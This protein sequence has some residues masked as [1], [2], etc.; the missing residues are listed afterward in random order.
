MEDSPD[1]Q[2]EQNL[3]NSLPLS[4]S[5]R[6]LFDYILRVNPQLKEKYFS[7]PR[8]GTEGFGDVGESLVKSLGDFDSD[9]AFSGVSSLIKDVFAHADK[10]RVQH[11]MMLIMFGKKDDIAP[12]KEYAQ[13]TGDDTLF[14]DSTIAEF[15]VPILQWVGNTKTYP[16]TSEQEQKLRSIYDGLQLPE[17]EIYSF[18]EACM[19][20]IEGLNANISKARSM[21]FGRDGAGDFWNQPE[22]KRSYFRTRLSYA[23]DKI[24]H[25]FPPAITN[26][27]LRASIDQH[28]DVPE[29]LMENVERSFLKSFSETSGFKTVD[30][31]RHALK[32]APYALR[33]IAERLRTGNFFIVV[34]FPAHAYEEV[35]ANGVRNLSEV[36]VST[37]SSAGSIRQYDVT[38]V[39]HEAAMLGLSPREYASITPEQRPKYFLISATVPT[40][41]LATVNTRDYGKSFAAVSAKTVSGRLTLSLG[42]SLNQSNPEGMW[43]ERL[44]P[45]K[46]ADVLAPFIY[47][48]LVEQYKLPLLHTRKIQYALIFHQDGNVNRRARFPRMPEALRKL[49]Y[50]ERPYEPGFFDGVSEGFGYDYVEAQVLGP[51]ASDTFVF[52]KKD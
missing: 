15:C 19:P 42:D 6:E 17:G 11:L 5:P 20:F 16:L 25:V 3:R 21:Y 32:R 40:R 33:V 4:S 37:F 35:L 23:L 48:A 39:E 36:G 30:E 29:A 38:R 46:Y 8:W 45:G 51:V 14:L 12:I 9:V 34:N 24:A 10:S 2:E 1:G 22:H 44:I 28:G 27:S 50:S 26:D 31:Y 41:A 13:R 47:L 18:A 7:E 52:S 49:K 43:D